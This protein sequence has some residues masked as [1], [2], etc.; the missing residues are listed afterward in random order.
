MR[1][2]LFTLVIICLI[3]TGCSED[4]SISYNN[5]TYHVIVEK[6][7]LH[8]AQYPLIIYNHGGGYLTLEPFEL[9]KLA[10][11]LAKAGFLVWIPE[12]SLW[13][14]E[15]AFH[16]YKEAMAISRLLLAKALN[17]NEV[18]KSNINIA[19]FCLGSWATLSEHIT[20]PVNS[21]ILIGFGAPFDDASLYDM[22]YSLAN[23]TQLSNLKPKVL[24]MVTQG[25]TKVATEPA[26]ILCEKLISLNKTVACVEY[27]SGDHLSLAGNKTYIEDL[28]RYLLGQ[29]IN[30][31]NNIKTN[32]MVLERWEEVRKAGYW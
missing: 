21:L 8:Q 22:V 19:G 9:R 1:Q 7:K 27:K 13:R 31:T 16:N 28:K 25:D 20:S 6:P 18:D 24:V 12:R 26:K 32:K 3:F 15:T 4:F 5:K 2:L 10:K 30:T 29:P 11:E 23:N 17:S 14:P